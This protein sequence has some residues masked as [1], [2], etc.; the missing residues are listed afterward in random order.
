M[1]FIHGNFEIN[2]RYEQN[3]GQ[4]IKGIIFAVY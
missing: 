2:I 4:I 3:H 1:S